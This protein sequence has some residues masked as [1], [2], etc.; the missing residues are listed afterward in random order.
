MHKTYKINPE[1]ILSMEGRNTLEVPHLDKELLITESFVERELVFFSDMTTS[2]LVILQ[3]TDTHS[4][5]H[6]KL[7][8]ALKTED[9]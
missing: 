9:T 7:D 6:S 3:W 5:V 8:L 1:K 2:G 4:R